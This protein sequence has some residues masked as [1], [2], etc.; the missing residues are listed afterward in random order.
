[1]TSHFLTRSFRDAP[2]SIEESFPPPDNT[3]VA[4]ESQVP[5]DRVPADSALVEFRKAVVN[6]V[7]AKDWKAAEEA[8]RALI[9]KTAPAG[10]APPLEVVAEYAMLLA[11]HGQGTR[12][13]EL[14]GEIVARDE[15]WGNGAVLNNYAFLLCQ[16]ESRCPEALKAADKALALDPE[17]PAFLHTRGTILIQLGR[18]DEAIETLE[19]AIRLTPTEKRKAI[20]RYFNQLGDAYLLAGNKQQALMNWRRA[21]AEVPMNR[22]LWAKIRRYDP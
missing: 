2:Q 15:T 21:A 9:D 11:T 3:P 10:Q 20:W 7:Q 4:I 18:I 14:F 17:N 8:Y 16:R 5:T 12:A 6:A 13:L 22:R 1:M 19:E